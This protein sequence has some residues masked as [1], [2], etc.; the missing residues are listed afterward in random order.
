MIPSLLLP[1]TEALFVL[2]SSFRASV[3]AE[4]EVSF[5]HSSLK[6]ET[7]KFKPKIQL[8]FAPS[9]SNCSQKCENKIYTEMQ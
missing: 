1:V 9:D 5:S 3:I 4:N 7:F 2:L 8:V 6:T